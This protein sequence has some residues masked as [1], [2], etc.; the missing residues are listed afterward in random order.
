MILITIIFLAYIIDLIVGDPYGFPHPVIYMG[1]LIS[2]E[3][4]SIR[5]S[6]INKKIG[7]F[8]IWIL[9]VLV[10]FI[11]SSLIVEFANI[12]KVYYYNF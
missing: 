4:K 9:T 12:N 2:F 5:K 10:V 1:K 7:G 8:I 11:L 6:K 3:E